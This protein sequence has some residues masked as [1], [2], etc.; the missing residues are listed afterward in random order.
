MNR[1]RI[2]RLLDYPASGDISVARL[3]G[4][5]PVS[6]LFRG[7]RRVG[8]FGQMLFQIVRAAPPRTVQST[9]ET[10]ARYQDLANSLELPDRPPLT[11]FEYAVPDEAT[12]IGRMAELAAQMVIDNYCAAKISDR[13]ARAMR[14]QHAKSHGC[15]EAEFIVRNDLP[16]E[17]TTQLFRPGARY[18]TTVRFSNGVGRRQSDKKLDARG[19]SIKLHGLDTPTLLRTL[20]PDKTRDGEHDF[21]LSSFPVFFCKNVVDYS[22]FMDAV[23]APHKT[24]PGRF[25]WIACWFAFIVQ[26]PRQFFMFFQTGIQSVL[27]IRD[28]LTAT[29]HSMS[30][31]LFGEDKVVRYV[32]GPAGRRNNSA[33]WWMFFWPRSESFLQDALVS[34]LDPARPGDDIVFDFSIRVRH[35]ANSDDAEDASRRW[36]APLDRTVRLGRIAIPKQKFLAPDRLYDCEHMT[37]NPWNCLQQHRPLGSVNRMRLAVYLASLQVRQKL[38]MVAS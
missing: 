14:D 1:S 37:F 10:K 17:F 4:D 11:K 33:R 30:P 34:D 27:T 3:L 7:L 20:V 29:Y 31:F 32:V 2:R 28:P 25:R 15:V 9:A 16:A 6:L 35:S 22:R 19:M 38:N 13:S 5:Q 36:T 24:W 8:Q 23:T 26:Y 21:A 18:P 12:L